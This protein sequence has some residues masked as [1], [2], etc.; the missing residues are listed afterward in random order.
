MRIAVCIFVVLTTILVAT[1]YSAEKPYLP[2]SLLSLID[3][4]N[5]PLIDESV[6]DGMF[7]ST[8]PQQKGDDHGHYLRMEDGEYVMA[9]MEGPG[10]VT[11][12]WS[13]NAHG[14]LRI[15]LDD[16]TKPAIEC[17]FKD[18]FE[19]RFPPFASPIS[20]RSS[21]GWYSYFPIG[22]EKYC[23]ISVTEDPSLSEKRNEARKPKKVSLSVKG[24][25][26]LKLIVNDAGDG[27]GNDLR[28]FEVQDSGALRL[29]GDFVHQIACF[30]GDAGSS[31]V[32]LCL[33][34][35]VLGLRSLLRTGL[36]GPAAT[37]AASNPSI[38]RALAR[39][40]RTR[41]GSGW[42][43]ARSCPAMAA[44]LIKVAGTVWCVVFMAIYDLRGFR[45]SAMAA[46]A[47]LPVQWR[48]CCPLI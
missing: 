21:G 28:G 12:I 46:R 39:I 16:K 6:K 1:A 30:Q 20:M 5:L 44:S 18:I 17:M 33:A 22:Y 47:W 9:E 13:A 7:S 38:W 48:S 8:D 32:E 26:E 11:R 42:P 10:V 15:Y 4:E 43:A 19:D 40:S 36:L 27:F 2:G 23:K 29:L 45:L 3:L 41:D 35:D 34:R 14:K 37:S 24:V 25:K 31:L